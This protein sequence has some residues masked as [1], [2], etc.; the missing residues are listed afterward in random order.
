[1]VERGG[2][3]LRLELQLGTPPLR[4]GS[5]VFGLHLDLRIRTLDLVIGGS[6]AVAMLAII[7]QKQAARRD[8]ARAE[9][10]V[11]ARVAD[12]DI[13]AFAIDVRGSDFTPG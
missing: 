1:M 13:D 3:F 2:E 6:F 7:L 12:D 9:A 4:S 11:A 5:R 8:L 10:A